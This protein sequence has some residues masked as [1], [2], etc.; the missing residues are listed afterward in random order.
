M[1]TPTKAPA[2]AAVP[3]SP[4]SGVLKTLQKA[5]DD[6]AESSL[7]A[8]NDAAASTKKALDDTGKAVAAAAAEV[9]GSAAKKR[10]E[11]AATKLQAAQRGQSERKETSTLRAVDAAAQGINFAIRRQMA[12]AREVRSIE[13]KRSG[14]LSVPRATDTRMATS[15]STS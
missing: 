6:L 1:S 14:P 13:F 9:D 2:T 12:I 15:R 4:I 11:E 5:S 3:A 10:K 8:I 7:K